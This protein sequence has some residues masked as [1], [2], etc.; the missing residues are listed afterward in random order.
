MSRT[1]KRASGNPAARPRVGGL[2]VPWVARWSD[3]EPS[4]SVRVTWTR[5]L[6]DAGQLDV[7][8]RYADERSGDRDTFGWLWARADGPATGTPQFGQLHPRRQRQCMDELRCQVCGRRQPTSRS[9]WLL[10]SSDMQTSPPRTTHAPVCP[11]CMRQALALC[12]H[13]S[14]GGWQAF[15]AQSVEPVGV[16]ADV[17]DPD[18][19]RVQMKGTLPLTHPWAGRALAKQRVVALHGCEPFTAPSGSR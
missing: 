13:L 18:T 14:R 4:G 16:Y 7:L 11:S 5:K 8:L 3:E 17:Y 9:T 10:P 19:G 12:P 6:N 1:R 15:S 2:P